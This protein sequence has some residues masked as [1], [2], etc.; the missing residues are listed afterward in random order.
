MI[1]YLKDN[2]YKNRRTSESLLS[3]RRFPAVLNKYKQNLFHRQ[4]SV[5]AVAEFIKHNAY[6]IKHCSY[7][8]KPQS[9]KKQYSAFLLPRVYSVQTGK[10]QKAQRAQYHSGYF[11][12]SV[13]RS[14]FCFCNFYS[15]TYTFLSAVMPQPTNQVKYAANHL[16]CFF[17]FKIIAP[18]WIIVNTK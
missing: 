9:Y 11:I 14:R 1:P 3:F 10:P 8:Q 7:T 17:Y 18:F 12:F 15:Y 13:W 2:A 4:F 6:Q 5:F 16:H